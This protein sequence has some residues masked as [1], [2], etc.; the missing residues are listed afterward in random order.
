MG[1]AIFNIQNILQNIVMPS[2]NNIDALHYVSSGTAPQNTRL[3][4]AD[5]E[6]AQ[7]QLKIGYEVGGAVT[8]DTVA[9]TYTTLGGT[10]PYWQESFNTNDYIPYVYGGSGSCTVIDTAANALSDNQWTITEAETNDTFGFLYSS[11]GGI[12][13]H[14]VYEGDQCTKSFWNAIRN[15][16]SFQLDQRVQGIEGFWLVQYNANGN[17]EGSPTWFANT[18]SNGGGP[19]VT[20]GQGTTPTSNYLITTIATGP[21][22][23]PQGTI[24]SDTTHYYVL[25]VVWSDLACDP[26]APTVEYMLAAAWKAQRYNILPTPCIDYPHIQFSWM[27]SLGMR[28]QFTFSKK[29]E[30]SVNAKRNDFLKEA[31]DY[32]SNTYNITP[33]DRGFTTYSQTLKETYS[34]NTD[35]INDQEAELLEHLFTSPDVMVRFSTGSMANQW[36][37]VNMVS[38]KYVEKTYQKNK[39]FQYD[40]KFKLAHNIKSQRG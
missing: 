21:A 25:P 19:N 26:L 3:R 15:P 13:V 37:P 2:Q 14:N 28:D 39:L 23:F 7:Y 9:A 33:Q 20:A 1:D 17:V 31:A 38:S 34:A 11:P 32:N 30:K 40:V 27:N 24:H 4:I 6:L 16:S 36:L 12:D 22:N 10:Q 5:G 35:Y 29:N 8:V 18:Q